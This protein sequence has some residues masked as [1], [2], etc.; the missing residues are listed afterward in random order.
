[1]SDGS[2]SSA[3]RVACGCLLAPVVFL[4][5]AAIAIAIAY[6]TMSWS[7]GVEEAARELGFVKGPS[8]GW[9]GWWVGSHDGADAAVAA[10]YV[11]NSGG[12][13]ASPG[14]RRQPMVEVAVGVGGSMPGVVAYSG[15]D[16]EGRVEAPTAVKEAMEA[17]AAS[18]GWV[19][20]RPAAPP[21]P[22][23][24]GVVWVHRWRADTPEAAEIEERLDALEQAARQAKR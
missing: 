11:M 7:H 21:Y 22:F 17:F 24:H 16:W 14:N 10:T 2:A 19:E 4:G 20:V 6:G 18:H 8:Y 9:D 23:D 13:R 1:M 5:P 15:T 12:T 3:R